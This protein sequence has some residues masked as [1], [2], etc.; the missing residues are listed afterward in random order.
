VSR[1]LTDAV[2]IFE[3]AAAAPAGDA[4]SELSILYD[5]DGQLRIVQTEGWNP[6]AL[7]QH[8]GARTSYHVS[9]NASGV[10]VDGRGPGGTC[11]IQSDKPQVPNLHLAAGVPQYTLI[12]TLLDY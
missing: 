6:D 10:V 11:R 12:R 4:S 8:Y 2:Q 1:F 7:R 9:R 3:T 5:A